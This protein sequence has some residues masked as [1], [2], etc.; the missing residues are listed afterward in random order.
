M[1][2]G[3]TA[4]IG[5]KD[6]TFEEFA[7]GCARAFGAPVMMRDDPRDAPVPDSFVESDYHS[8]SIKKARTRLVELQG[9]DDA[10][11]D[12]SAASEH[13]E[14]VK[15]RAECDAKD[16]ALDDRYR[17]MLAKVEKWQPPTSDHDG[18]KRFMAE[19]IESSIKFDCGHVWEPPVKLTGAA[20]REEQIAKCTRDLEYHAREA[21]K[22]STRNAERNAWVKALR[23]S[24]P[25]PPKGTP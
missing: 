9:M 22:E 24:V 11:C 20:W 17:A 14:S 8:E 5:D 25:H 13:S 15:V 21:R 12:A 6:A 23:D 19:Q 16:R 1:P 7:W 2:T 10:A 4:C 18:L 3:Y